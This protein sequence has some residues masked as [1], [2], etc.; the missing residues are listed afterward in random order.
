[1]APKKNKSKPD[2]DEA[3][4]L[5][6]GW[7]KNTMTEA[8]V[9]ELEDMKMLQNRAVIQWRG[10]EGEDHQYEG[11]LETVVFCNFVDRGLAVPVSEFFHSLLQFWEIQF[12]HLTTQLILHLSIFTHLCEA[13]LGVLPYFHFF[14]HCCWR[15]CASTSPKKPR[16]V[17]ILPAFW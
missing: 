15:M 1:M 10:A 4:D 6:T 12:H 8:A 9:Q 3:P 5:A 11:T 14:Q 16:R 2:V 17:L 7:K 13:F